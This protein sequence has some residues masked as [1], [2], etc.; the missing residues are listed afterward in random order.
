[1]RIPRPLESLSNPDGEGVFFTD[2]FKHGLRLPR[3]LRRSAT[4]QAG[5]GGT[6]AELLEDMASASCIGVWSLRIDTRLSLKR[7][8][9]TKRVIEIIERVRSKIAKEERVFKTLL[10]FGNLFKAGLNERSHRAAAESRAPQ[11]KKDS[12][13]RPTVKTP[14]Q[15]KG[16]SAP[17][18]TAT[19]D[20]REKRV[21]EAEIVCKA[22]LQA[23]GKRRPRG[24]KED[25]AVLVPDDEE[26]ADA[27]LVNVA[28]PRKV[29]PFVNCFIDALRWSSRS[30]SSYR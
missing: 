4:P 3:S 16:A 17:E 26:D 6:S 1:M 27:E 8:I 28:C 18:V 5:R 23:T 2:A 9:A 20:C 10:D 14:R 22:H 29:V 24:P 30:W 7:P 13:Q 25:A 11:K 12:S 19:D 21:A 15:A